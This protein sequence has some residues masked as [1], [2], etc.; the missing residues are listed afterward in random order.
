MVVSSR[1]RL[2]RNVAGLPFLSRCSDAQ[3]SELAY[4]LSQTLTSLP[5][6]EPMRY[7]DVEKADELERQMLVERHLIS[8]NQAEAKGPRGVAISPSETLAAMVNEEDHLRLQALRSGLQL[9]QCYSDVRGLDDQ[10]EQHI[11]YAFSSRFGYLTACPTNVGTALRVSVM[12]HLPALKMSGELEKALRAGRDMNL[13]VRGMYG[14]GTEALGD[15]FQVSNQTTLGRGEEQ[16]ITDF[17]DQI[18]PAFINY[19]LRQREVLLKA[20]KA[21]LEDKIFR[22]WAVLR[23]ARLMSSE[24]TL[25]LLSHIRLGLA[26]HL[27]PGLTIELL[28]QLSLLTQ[29]AHL[30]QLSGKS[31]TPAER[32]EYRAKLLRDTLS[33]VKGVG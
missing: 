24:E 29:P 4:G 25:Y 23:S 32:G 27:L 15:F 33:A 20:R 12:L 22:A 18:V 7:V 5:L 9:E 19:E 30:Q 16:I 8:R 11:S 6:A 2:A 3:R 21:A 14:E 31:M 10:L 13:A 17:R 26:L 28:N 1:V